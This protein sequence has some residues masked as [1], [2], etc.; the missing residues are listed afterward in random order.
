MGLQSAVGC[1][2]AGRA[3]G[4]GKLSSCEAVVEP[5]CSVTAHEAA[6]PF[7][8]IQGDGGAMAATRSGLS[9]SL[10][11]ARDNKNKARWQ[12]VVTTWQVLGQRVQEC[13]P[14]HTQNCGS[15]EAKMPKPIFYTAHAYPLGEESHGVVH[16]ARSVATLQDQRQHGEGSGGSG[17][18]RG[19]LV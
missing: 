4:R 18:W 6:I 5:A 9:Q 13:Y 8:N 1:A 10:T 11:A 3:A 17:A 7:A 15:P 19:R 2:G 14:P 12:A 16:A